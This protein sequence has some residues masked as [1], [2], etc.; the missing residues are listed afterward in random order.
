[1]EP[2]RKTAQGTLP[3][4]RIIWGGLLFSPIILGLVVW[5]FFASQ[6]SRPERIS[7]SDPLT[8][9][10][11]L[12]AAIVFAAALKL[13]GPHPQGFGQLLDEGERQRAFGLY[14]VRL[15][16]LEIPAMI[17]FVLALVKGAPVLFV[18]FFLVSITGFALSYPDR[19]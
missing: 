9:V 18:P 14:I 16:L 12:L 17:G 11:L 7:F 19:T 6:P 15:A 3:R 13:Q 2:H 8:L 1:M 10:C 4:A 5:V